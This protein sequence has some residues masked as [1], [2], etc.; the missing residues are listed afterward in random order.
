MSS[1]AAFRFQL[2][3]PKP[4]VQAQ[5]RRIAGGLAQQPRQ[6]RRCGDF[7]I[8]TARFCIRRGCKMVHTPKSED[9]RRNKPPKYETAAHEIKINPVGHSFDPRWP[10]LGPR[11]PQLRPP[12]VT[13]VAL[14]GHSLAP[15]GHSLAIGGHN[16]NP[17]WSQLDLRWSQLGIRWSQ[18]GLRWSQPGHRGLPLDLLSLS[19]THLTWTAIDSV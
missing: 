9:T 8:Q 2:R 12:V 3:S 1:L 7:L 4:S 17:R 6:G 13:A 16:C 15:G 11:W 14:G 10:Q 19:S 18:L 5:L